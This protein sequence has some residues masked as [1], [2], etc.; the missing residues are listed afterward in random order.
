VLRLFGART[1]R[2]E[3]SRVPIEGLAVSSRYGGWEGYLL[4]EV[5]SAAGGDEAVFQLAIRLYLIT[6]FGRGSSRSFAFSDLRRWA[7]RAQRLLGVPADNLDPADFLH[8]LAKGTRYVDPYRLTSLL[9]SKDRRVPVRR[10][11]KSIYCPIGFRGRP[12]AASPYPDSVELTA[13][14]D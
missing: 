5:R 12:E 14:L 6:A 3:V 7:A 11:I 8:G 9:L 10:L 1:V 4:P 2:V 13:S